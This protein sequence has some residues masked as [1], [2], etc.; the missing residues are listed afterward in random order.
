MTD[1]ERGELL[2][3]AGLFDRQ[4]ARRESEW[5]GLCAAAAGVFIRSQY[6]AWARTDRRRSHRLVQRL[7]EAGL[8]R[9]FNAGRGIGRCVHL[10]SRRVYKALGMGDSR[11]R[12]RSST[13]HLLQR[14]LALDFRIA[15]GADPAWLFGG[16]AQAAAF[17]ELGAPDSVLPA[18]TYR[19]KDGGE[20]RTVRFPA[21]WPVGLKEVYRATLFRQ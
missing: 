6:E 11:H 13:G 17:R 9:E 7:A 21:G 2:V 18:R 10:G 1:R 4:V 3:G 14:L 20:K 15:R 8:G 16:D 5:V 19:A 12:R